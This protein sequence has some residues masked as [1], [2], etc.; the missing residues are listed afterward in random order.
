M[1]P[2]MDTASTITIKGILSLLVQNVD[3]N[4][5]RR[6]ISLGMGDPSAYSCFH[7]TRAT[8]QAVVDSLQS[9]KFNG[10]AP[11]SGL[12]QTRRFRFNFD[13]WGFIS[14]LCESFD[15]GIGIENADDSIYACRLLNFVLFFVFC[16]FESSGL[17]RMILFFL[18]LLL[19]VSN[20]SVIQLFYMN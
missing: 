1:N 8:Q 11:T 18:F 13:F 7:T 12:P 6:L 4:N 14:F 16:K 15:L 3:E 19:V 9:Q 20:S 5:G 2:E 17:V 10:Y